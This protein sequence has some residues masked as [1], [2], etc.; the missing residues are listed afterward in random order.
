MAREILSSNSIMANI[1]L[2]SGKI[3]EGR[4]MFNKFIEMLSQ[5]HTVKLNNK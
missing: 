1:Y 4:N 3:E 2:E 5:L